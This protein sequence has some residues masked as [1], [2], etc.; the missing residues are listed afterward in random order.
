MTAR[1]P[2]IIALL[3]F[4]LTGC[5][6]TFDAT[7]LGAMRAVRQVFD[8]TERANPGKVLPLHACRE[9]RALRP[10]R[11]GTDREAAA[12]AGPADAAGAAV[13]EETTG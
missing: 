13:A 5:A 7:T 3:L 12:L 8:P 11:L 4:A 6:Q 9:W 1:G 2:A 10:E